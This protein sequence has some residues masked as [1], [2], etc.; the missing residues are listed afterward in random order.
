MLTFREMRKRCKA[1]GFHCHHIIPISVIENRS[2]AR[3]FGRARSAG[4]EP[5][6]FITNGMHLP[7]TEELA[8]AFRLPLH[9]GPHRLY[10]EIVATQVADWSRLGPKELVKRISLL[11]TSLRLGLR[12]NP[13]SINDA[14]AIGH[15][16]AE[17]FRQLDAAISLLYGST[18]KLG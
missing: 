6:D 13:V 17:D 8:V 9:R 18:E 10:N 14:A 15:A 4:F 16:L 3:I 11:Q 12:R 1:Q 5:Q 2:L 7:A